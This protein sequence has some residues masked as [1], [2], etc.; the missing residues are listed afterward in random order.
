VRKITAANNIGNLR[1]KT[2]PFLEKASVD[3]H[4]PELPNVDK[5][6][7]NVDPLHI[8]KVRLPYGPD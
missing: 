6:K 2:T 1:S 5:L 4:L 7:E 3:S 8:F